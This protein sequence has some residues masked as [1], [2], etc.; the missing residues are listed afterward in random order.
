VTAELFI[1]RNEQETN[2]TGR[3]IA[4]ALAL[5]L[6][7]TSATLAQ[8]GTFSHTRGYMHIASGSDGMQASPSSGVESQR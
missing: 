8:S 7:A 5:L 3:K 1:G 2:M 6:S 4:V